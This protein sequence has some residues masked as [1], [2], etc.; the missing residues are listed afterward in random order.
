MVYYIWFI[1]YEQRRHFEEKININ[2]K[3]KHRRS[4]QC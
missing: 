1:F 3:T 4:G 2:T